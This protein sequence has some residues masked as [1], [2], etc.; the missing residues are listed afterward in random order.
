MTV[1]LASASP[2]RRDLLARLEIPFEVQPSKSEERASFPDEDPSD[3]AR[4]VAALKA[5]DVARCRPHDLVIGADT[6]VAVDGDI[7]GKPRTTMEAYAM[8][9][10]LNG[11]SHDVITAVCVVCHGHTHLGADRTRVQMRWSTPQELWA[12]VAGGEPMDKAG[13]YGIQGRGGDLVTKYQG[14]FNTV[15]GLP[16]TLTASF[17]VECGIHLSGTTMTCCD[18]CESRLR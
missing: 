7:L 1:V 6:V 13:A 2:R 9:E 14:C 3:Y 18:F 16:L 5:R 10:R 17:L 4:A 11:R 8:L 15:V 12:Y